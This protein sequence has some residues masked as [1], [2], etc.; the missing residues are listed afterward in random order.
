MFL[1]GF[2]EL[3]KGPWVA[4]IGELKYSSGLPVRELS[5]AIEMS[6]MG[7]KQHCEA[8]CELGYIERWRVPRSDVGRPEILYRLTERSSALFPQAG[9]T[10]SLGMLESARTL[11]GDTAPEKLFV[12]YFQDL[13]NAWGSKLQKC[14]SLVEKA[15][16]LTDLREKEG[17]FARCKYDPERGFRIEEV[18]NPLWHVFQKYPAGASLEIR[19]ME[20]LLGSK[21]LRREIPQGKNGIA[22]VEYEIGTL[23]RSEN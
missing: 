16:R 9:V 4:I 5:Q 20:R 2:R 17:C 15:T 19:M 1:P 3:V 10:F 6:Y 7:T 13:E 12:Q 14:H 11:F 18:H 23:G 21:V 8:L 22:K